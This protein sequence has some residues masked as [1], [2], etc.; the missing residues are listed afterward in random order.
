VFAWGIPAIIAVIPMVLGWYGPD[1]QIAECWIS[2]TTLLHES[3]YYLPLTLLFLIN[4]F[5]YIVMISK[6]TKEHMHKDLLWYVI[7]FLF[8]YSPAIINR[9]LET[10][11]LNYFILEE[12]AVATVTTKG[13]VNLIV[14]GA[15][16]GVFSRKNINGNQKHYDRKSDEPIRLSSEN[17]SYFYFSFFQHSLSLFSS[18]TLIYPP[19]QVEINESYPL[20]R[21]QIGSPMPQST[22]IQQM[23]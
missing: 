6:N 20:L 21:P 5:M 19:E 11:S 12:I 18:E 1:S 16:K 3:I 15:L 13:F 14:W 22:L 4:L 9:I 10:A 23:P 7:A 8:L 2:V 17:R